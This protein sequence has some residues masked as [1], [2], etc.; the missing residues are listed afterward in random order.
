MNF[1][2]FVLL[3]KKIVKKEFEKKI[4]VEKKFF[5]ESF[6]FCFEKMHLRAKLLH[7]EG[8]GRSA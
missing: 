7:T 3:V 6:F 1:F 4:V 2:L 5:G 8:V